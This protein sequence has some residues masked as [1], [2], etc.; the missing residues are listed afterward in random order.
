MKGGKR[1]SSK[2]GADKGVKPPG[3]RVEQLGR[4]PHLFLTAVGQHYRALTWAGVGKQSKN[5][6]SVPMG[7][8]VLP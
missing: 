3:L 8:T 2:S 1:L 5:T 6:A 4:R 7:H